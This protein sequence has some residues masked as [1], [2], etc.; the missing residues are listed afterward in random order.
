[1]CTT[2]ADPN[3]IITRWIRGVTYEG[4]RQ[5]VEAQGVETIGS[6]PPTA[7]I[8]YW[9]CEFSSCGD[10]GTDLCS[11]GGKVKKSP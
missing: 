8:S 7:W 2:I 3:E 9:E 6:P 1:M 4:T 11:A 5:W 10:D